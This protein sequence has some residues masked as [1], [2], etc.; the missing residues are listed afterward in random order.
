MNNANQLP[1]TSEILAAAKAAEIAKAAFKAA[2]GK[3]A[4]TQ[5]IHFVAH[6]NSLTPVELAALEAEQAAIHAE[7]ADGSLYARDNALALQR[8][9]RAA[10]IDGEL[11]A[12]LERWELLG[13]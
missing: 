9:Q 8:T 1:I 12:A 4:A 13:G 3:R 7:L 10:D 5:V 11:M 2:C 6:R